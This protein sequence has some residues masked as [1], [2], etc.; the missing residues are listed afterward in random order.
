MFIVWILTL[1][2]FHNQ[3]Y[4]LV[5]DICEAAEWSVNKQMQKCNIRLW[6]KCAKHVYGILDYR[7]SNSKKKIWIKFV[8]KIWYQRLFES[9]FKI[10]RIQFSSFYWPEWWIWHVLNTDILKLNTG[11][12]NMEKKRGTRQKNDLLELD[13]ERK[14]MY[15]WN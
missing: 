10:A 15:P 12:Y 8:M 9:S 13:K 11:W 7:G 2:L 1:V 4:F 6:I 3:V 14:A 5:H